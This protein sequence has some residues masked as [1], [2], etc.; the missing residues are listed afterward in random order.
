MEKKYRNTDKNTANE[1]TFMFQMRACKK[2]FE[3]SK[4]DFIFK[5][6]EQKKKKNLF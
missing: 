2:N 1:N 3:I 5:L 4:C 6:Q